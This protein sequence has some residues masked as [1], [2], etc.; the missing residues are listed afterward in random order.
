MSIGA[1]AIHPNFATQQ[2]CIG[3]ESFIRRKCS[4]GHCSGITNLHISLNQMMMII[5]MILFRYK[6]E[7]LTTK[8]TLY[9]MRLIEKYV[10]AM[11]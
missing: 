4:A 10:S 3:Y 9:E 7:P 1:R 5:F 2:T 8:I 11:K 6:K